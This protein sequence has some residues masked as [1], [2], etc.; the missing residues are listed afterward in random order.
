MYA[1]QIVFQPAGPRVAIT[2]GI[3]NAHCITLS[4]VLSPAKPVLEANDRK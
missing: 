2:A 4:P 1:G 3:L